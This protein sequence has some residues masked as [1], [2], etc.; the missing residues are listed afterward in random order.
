MSI[1][2]I[3]IGIVVIAIIGVGGFFGYRSYSANSAAKA[4]AT[5]ASKT[6]TSTPEQVQGQE[7]KVGTGAEAK[8][9][10]QVTVDYIGKFADGT[11]FDSSIDRKEPLVFTLGAEGI[12][13]GFQI[14]VNG[15]KVGGERLL[16]V[17]PSLGYGA[18][19]IKDGSGKV[20][21]PANSTLIFDV[22]LLK[23]EAAP[24]AAP[25]PTTKK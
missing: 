3:I 13:P 19:D 10:M 16:A 11:V 7:V 20:T 1:K 12:I 17:P 6:A 2:N 18:T 24:V 22:K 23:V 15:M 14:G 25:A 21:I 8:P 4:A 9:G 5:D